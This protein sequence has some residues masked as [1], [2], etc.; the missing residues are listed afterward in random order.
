M[1]NEPPRGW[2]FGR[3]KIA[4]LMRS[5]SSRKSSTEK[6]VADAGV[7]KRR[8]PWVV[9]DGAAQAEV[10]PVVLFTPPSK[11]RR[12]QQLVDDEPPS[13][14][15]GHRS[16]ASPMRDPVPS[17]ETSPT[18][19]SLSPSHISPEISAAPSVQRVVAVQD[20]SAPPTLPPVGGRASHVLRACCKLVRRALLLFLIAATC[21]LLFWLGRLI[22]GGVSDAF[23][24][25]RASDGFADW[26]T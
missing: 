26:A 8:R 21:W 20:D 18:R 11:E 22:L 7:Q 15:T 16:W 14:P 19:F 25:A 5:S 24:D 17:P 23:N 10:N 13:P 4:M 12:Y 3:P 1:A 2:R 9:S 6:N